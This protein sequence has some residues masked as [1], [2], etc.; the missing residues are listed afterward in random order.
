MQRIPE[1]AYLNHGQD[2]E[3]IADFPH[4]TSDL[5]IDQLTYGV[6]LQDTLRTLSIIRHDPSSSRMALFGDT[7]SVA[8]HI[9]RLAEDSETIAARASYEQSTYSPAETRR[10]RTIT[11]GV[12]SE[13]TQD[14]PAICEQQ[15]FIDVCERIILP[16]VKVTASPDTEVRIVRG[17]QAPWR[18]TPE[19]RLLVESSVAEGA[20]RYLQVV[21]GR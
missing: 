19:E 17:V 4:A 12:L 9:A 13:L 16:F 14:L 5:L 18:L 21:G 6:A 8:Q 15:D 20:E 10:I 7:E 2:G 3:V 1:A 11:S